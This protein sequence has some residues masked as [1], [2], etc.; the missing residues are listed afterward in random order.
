MKT[1]RL[2]SDAF[3]ASHP[4]EA[5]L[6][7][8]KFPSSELAMLLVEVQPQ[9]A[10][11]V[12]KRMAPLQAAEC[13]ELMTGERP[14]EV[15][16]NLPL[17]IA[18]GLL[19]RMRTGG[20]DSLFESIKPEVGAP[21]R[22]LLQYPEDSV[23]SLMDPEVIS[24]STGMTVSE[25]L[26]RIRRFLR[27]TTDFFYVTGENQALVGVTSMRDLMLARPNDLLGSVTHAPVIH[28]SAAEDRA[29]IAHHPGWQKFHELPVVGDNGAFV[30]VIRYKMFRKL[31]SKRAAPQW[32]RTVLSMTLVLG[33]MYWIMASST[34]EGLDAV[35]KASGKISTSKETRHAE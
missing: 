15:I 3:L 25:A 32:S 31:A 26:K 10:A 35:I 14:R 24:L 4:G 27:H 7:L 8:E 6:I 33:E 28:L 12:L 19:R 11:E 13:L 17:H 5:V 16:E 21:L 2:L 34:I 9:N 20:R 1:E 22:L 23:G 30:G 29:A 18:A